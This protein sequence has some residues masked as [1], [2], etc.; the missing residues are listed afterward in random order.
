MVLPPLQRL[1]HAI[2]RPCAP[3]GVPMPDLEDLV[4]KFGG[5]YDVWAWEMRCNICLERLGLN[6][7]GTPW[8]GPAGSF[9]WVVVCATKP[10]GHAFHKECIQLYQRAALAQGKQY[11]ECPECRAPV[12]NVGG[13][14]G[15][16]LPPA[17]VPPPP[18][19]DVDIDDGPAIPPIRRS[20]AMQYDTPEYEPRYNVGS[21]GS[22][23]IEDAIRSVVDRAPVGR[24]YDDDGLPVRL[25]NGDLQHPRLMWATTEGQVLEALGLPT[26]YFDA[27]FD[28]WLFY[29]VERDPSTPDPGWFTMRHF[30]RPIAWGAGVVTIAAAVQSLGGDTADVLYAVAE[31]FGR[32]H[33]YAERA[34]FD[35]IFLFLVARWRDRDAEAER[36]NQGAPTPSLL[37]FAGMEDMMRE[38]LED[39]EAFRDTG[40]LRQSGFFGP[41]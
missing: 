4:T 28:Y 5:G 18:A 20:L 25:N 29:R 12:I 8:A 26:A 41:I 1:Q 40:A 34:H 22:R 2:C 13:P 21:E 19:A 24:N 6:P 37:T 31:L 3:T 27:I 15:V 33:M 39:G 9:A 10:R 23:T 32:A 35:T 38:I 36:Q 11:A 17:A 16:P 14:E 7:D 30:T